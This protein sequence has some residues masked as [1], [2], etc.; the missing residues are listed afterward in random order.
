MK[1]GILK[2]VQRSR[3]RRHFLYDYWT[4]APVR[5]Y[6]TDFTKLPKGT[7]RMSSLNGLLGTNL[8]SSQTLT[9]KRI[10]GNFL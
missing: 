5:E 3:Y 7:C 6:M 9:P 10:F 8:D 1:L 4:L 2:R